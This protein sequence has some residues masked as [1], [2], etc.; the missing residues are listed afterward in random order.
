MEEPKQKFIGQKE[1]LGITET[2]K[3]TPLDGKVLEVRFADGSTELLT[4]KMYTN[5]VTTE[6]I[7]ATAL[8][9][10]RTENLVKEVLVLFRE[11]NIRYDE[12]N[13]VIECIISSVTHNNT[14]ALNKLLG[15]KHEGEHTFLQ[16]DEILK[17]DGEQK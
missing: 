1:V 15:I 3:K 2:A 16:L 11:A 12:V 7:D 17:D 14:Q 10:L 9:K 13:H 8:R 5:I 6:K 4:E